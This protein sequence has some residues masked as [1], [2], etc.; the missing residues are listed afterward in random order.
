MDRERLVGHKMHEI[1]NLLHRQQFKE[2]KADRLTMIQSWIVE[3]IYENEGKDIFQKDIEAKFMM[4]RSTAT[5]AL[6]LMEK[7]GLVYRIP[8]S[9][10]ARLKKIC[11]TEKAGELYKAICVKI[12]NFEAKLTKGISKEE[13][14]IFFSVI[15]KM[16]HNMLES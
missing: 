12:S 10:D 7:N 14:D 8:V 3:Y 5:A 6:Q 1:I 2:S 13:L 16:K 9:Y 15:D 4:R 11:V